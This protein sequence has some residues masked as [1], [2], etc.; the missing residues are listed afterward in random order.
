ME[1]LGKVVIQV[2]PSLHNPEFVI[3]LFVEEDRQLKISGMKD[4][5]KVYPHKKWFNIQA[6]NVKVLSIL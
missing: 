5:Y 3:I 4:C 1:A 6:V 2:C